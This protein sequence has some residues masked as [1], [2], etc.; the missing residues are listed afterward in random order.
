M[1]S[2]Y[3]LF[4]DK[5]AAFVA[6]LE[7][8]LGATVERV[9]AGGGEDGC[10]RTMDEGLEALAGLV[11]AEAPAARM[12]LFE[13]Y[14]AGPRA[15]E[16]VEREILRAEDLVCERL[17]ESPERAAMPR[18]MATA[19]VGATLEI[20]RGH[21]MR[22]T[23]E[24]EKV[25]GAFSSMILSF[26][27]P[28]RP[29]RSAARP[30]EIRPET[31]EASDHAERAV[32]AFEALLAEG[33]Y[34]EL[35]MEQVASRAGMSRRTLYANFS[36]RKR[37]L[38]AAIDSAC[39][40]VA[41]VAL[42][43]YDR[44]EIPVDGLRAAVGALLALLA[45]K[46]N[47]AHL[48]LIASYEGGEPALRRRNRGL[49]PL[50]LLL[51]GIAAT[52]PGSAL[53]AIEQEA[54]FGGILS[55]LRRRV[56]EAGAPALAGLGPICTYI[57]LAPLV[58]PEQATIAAEGRAY[59]RGSPDLYVSAVARRADLRV[60]AVV[61]S[62][63]WKEARTVREVAR[64]V[65][66]PTSD[67]E[68]MLPELL[69]VGALQRAEGDAADGEPRYEP[70]L[71]L[72]S[73]G[74]WAEV[75]QGERE[76]ISG[77]I[78]QMVQFELEEAMA[79]G[80][81]DSRPERHLVRLPVWLDEQGWQEVNDQLTLTTEKCIEIAGRVRERFAADETREG[82]SARILLVS[83]EPPPVTETR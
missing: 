1:R 81:F 75:G 57:V 77:E 4:P 29:L 8:L 30:P 73:T 7:L 80:S 44:H 28:T 18:E 40:Q 74:D 5:E 49:R 22:K 52:P 12:C 26:R 37:L 42:P 63:G 56:I 3:E 60:N 24:L 47:L 62:F 34:A 32:R 2:F 70:R 20:L 69:E 51:R 14:V 36:D 13:A 17:S 58:G 25:V 27:P 33:R 68:S 53:T 9:F 23:G 31:T 39:A 59:R 78:G 19:A 41:A 76:T 48:L 16:L 11:A 43:A 10:E 21:L 79:T 72:I 50:R 46:P 38:S 15:A 83:F 65:G 67:V 54:I 45:S 55:L 6:T 64:E 66:L 82:F 61:L 35:T 71:P